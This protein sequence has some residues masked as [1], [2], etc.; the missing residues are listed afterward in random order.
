[1]EVPIQTIH[2]FPILDQKLIELLTSLKEDDW[3][4]PTRARHWTVK[5]IATHL[6]D[7]NLRTLSISRDRFI[8]DPP[9]DI[10]SYQSLVDYLNRLN[11]DWVS[12]TRR[13]SPSVLI[14][15]LTVTGKEYHDHLSSLDPFADAIFSVGWAG[16]EKSLNW[17]HVAREYTEKWHHQQQIREAV[18]QEIICTKELYQPVLETFIRAL[19]YHYRDV[20]AADGSIIKLV[21]EGEAGGV[22]S[23]RYNSNTWQFVNASTGSSTVV[24]LHQDDAWK[25]FTKGLSL[26]KAQEIIHIEGD[27]KLGRKIF[28]IL[29]VMA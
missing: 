27:Q 10:N 29:S 6:L 3:S 28:T 24:K 19:P 7:G 13:L 15:L 4:K 5:D 21:I 1:M 25:L 2:L 22:W 14:N 20:T 26:E 9:K 17:F 23:I 12:A 11:A 8:G 18:G 16:E